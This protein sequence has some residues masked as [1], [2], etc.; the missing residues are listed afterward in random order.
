MGL[1]MSV[2]QLLII[3]VI[4]ALIFGTKRLKE[5]GGDLGSAVKS[6]RKAMNTTGEA[7]EAPVET[8]KQLTRDEEKQ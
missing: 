2:P 3:L 8:P 1:A 5:V 6:F 4:V 7:D